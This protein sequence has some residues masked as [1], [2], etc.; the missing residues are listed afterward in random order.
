MTRRLDRPPIPPT[1]RKRPAD[2]HMPPYTPG[3]VPPPDG[4]LPSSSEEG[5]VPPT[6][7]PPKRKP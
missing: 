5:A 4:D 1:P 2:D 7:Y 6:T 3:G